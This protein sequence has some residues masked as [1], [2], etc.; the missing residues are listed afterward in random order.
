MT[1]EMNEMDLHSACRTGDLPSIKI[2]YFTN[3]TKLNEKDP[4]VRITQLGWGPLYRT[5]IC[6]HDEAAEYLLEQGA[7]PNVANNLGE[8]P[9]HQASDNSQYS[10]AELLLKYKADPNRQQ[11][12]GD[13]PLHHAAFRGDN[14]MIE[15]L[16]CKGADPNIPNFMVFFT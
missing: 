6:A 10:M 5:V 16:L 13:T 14:Q 12:D 11:N 4:V 3:P 2:S 7:D 1:S 15:I 8:T 9:L